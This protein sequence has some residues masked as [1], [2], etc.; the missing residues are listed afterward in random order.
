MSYKKCSVK[1]EDESHPR[2][3]AALRWCR[4]RAASR[5]SAKGGG[6]SLTPIPPS[7]PL[8]ITSTSPHDHCLSP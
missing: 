1:Q 8:P 3:G 5:V 2:L 7:F 6:F 4:K